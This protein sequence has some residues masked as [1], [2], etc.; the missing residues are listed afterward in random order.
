[1]KASLILIIIVFLLFSA[2]CTSAQPAPDDTSQPTA[3]MTHTAI[4]EATTPEPTM[5]VLTV[6]ATQQPE[7]TV[8]SPPPAADS[9]DPNQATL[10]FSMYGP[11][12]FIDSSEMA[13]HMISPD[14]AAVDWHSNLKRTICPNDI[15]WSADGSKLVL[16]T[17]GDGINILSIADKG[18]INLSATNAFS[19]NSSPSFSPDRKFITFFAFNEGAIYRIN[20]DGTGLVNLTPDARYRN[21]FESPAWSPAGDLIVYSRLYADGSIYCMNADGSAP[22]KLVDIGWNDKPRFSPDGRWLAFI[23]YNESQGFLY[24]MPIA[25]GSPRSLSGNQQDVVSYSW[26]PDGRYLVFRDFNCNG[27]CEHRYWMVEFGT[28]EAWLLNTSQ[29][30]VIWG[31]LEWSPLMKFAENR[32][33]CSGG[34]SKLEIGNL[35][36]LIGE[37]PSRVRTEPQKGENVVGQ[38][39]AD[40]TYILLDGPVCSEG[41]VW[42][43]IADPRLPGGSGWT[44]EGDGQEYWLEP[45]NP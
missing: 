31:P 21:S 8:T 20:V 40:E 16:A 17:T 45:V 10:D 38:F 41:L 28:G 5:A 36:Q 35:V 44:A 15:A 29:D 6:T 14:G 12:A 4:S 24:A 7:A 23:R 9:P 26:S 34:W 30:V 1:M 39:V 37:V 43:E 19:I 32:E 3:A 22:R 27:G 11:L 2:G 18:L 42:W 13:I 33:D 25:G